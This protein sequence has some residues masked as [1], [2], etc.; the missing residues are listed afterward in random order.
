MN[1]ILEQLKIDPRKTYDDSLLPLEKRYRDYIFR[2]LSSRRT[3][4]MSI[5][6]LIT[7]IVFVGSLKRPSYINGIM[8][9]MDKPYPYGGLTVRVFK[10]DTIS[11]YI[12]EKLFM[13]GF[14]RPWMYVLDLR[15]VE[16]DYSMEFMYRFI[17]SLL[18][19][20]IQRRGTFPKYMH[21]WVHNMVVKGN[22]QIYNLLKISPYMRELVLMKTDDRLAHKVIST[23]GMQFTQAARL[24]QTFLDEGRIHIF[25]ENGFL[26]RIDDHASNIVC[27]LLIQG[28][29]RNIDIEYFLNR[30]ST[31]HIIASR[32]LAMI[33]KG[34]EYNLL[35]VNII[36]MTSTLMRYGANPLDYNAYALHMADS[37]KY[38]DDIRPILHGCTYRD[39][40]YDNI[41]PAVP[42]NL[43]LLSKGYKVNVDIQDY[44]DGPLFMCPIPTNEEYLRPGN[45]VYFDDMTFWTDD[46]NNIYEDALYVYCRKMRG[47]RL[48]DYIIDEKK[49]VILP[50]IKLRILTHNPSTMTYEAEIY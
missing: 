17:P 27:Y 50:P 1:G 42:V 45:T 23:Y 46:M 6:P 41:H 32:F 13:N 25:E 33:V 14:L 31:P 38:G 19:T 20:C 18:P 24:F 12:I 30:V 4:S 21:N 47:I 49:Q 22:T 48:S 11:W 9:I 7:L 43:Y 15:D 34:Q 8:N 35:G 3:R 28:A 44:I 37:I 39:S 16:L 40:G 5:D 29:L 26:M 10:I 2:I 36:S